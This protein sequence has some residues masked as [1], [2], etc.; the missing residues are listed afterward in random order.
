MALELAAGQARAAESDSGEK[1][2]QGP[3]V[4]LTMMIHS[5]CKEGSA[6]LSEVVQGDFLLSSVLI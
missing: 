6:V 3:E 5:L 2:N 4:Q 1:T